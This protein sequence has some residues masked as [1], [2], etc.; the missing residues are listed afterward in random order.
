MAIHWVD[1]IHGS[2]CSAVVGRG[3]YLR[4]LPDGV[5]TRNGPPVPYVVK[6][7]EATLTKRFPD[8]EEA[9]KAAETACK[10][11]LSDALKGLDE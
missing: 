8:R 10:L 11:F 4:V 7:F 5:A 9:K 1:A 3:L 2:S 6:V